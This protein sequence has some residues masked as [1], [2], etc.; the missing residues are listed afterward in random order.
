MLKTIGAAVALSVGLAGVAMAQPVAMPVPADPAEVLLVKHDK[1]GYGPGRKLGHYKHKDKHRYKHRDDDDD[2]DR[3][4][5]S[6][7]R[8]WRG[9]TAPNWT[10]PRPA[11][12][13]APPGYGSS[14]PPVPYYYQ[15][16][17][18]SRGY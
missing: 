1:D 12:Y 6:T 11:P 15:P 9:S 18:Y 3:S 8:S 14:Y 2:D 4:R 5:R 16:P 17:P 13:Y 10:N 7:T